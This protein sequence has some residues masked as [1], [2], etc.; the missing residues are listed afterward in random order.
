MRLAR[1][2]WIAGL[3]ASLAAHGAGA[4]LLA[5]RG[6]DVR[7]ERAAG[8]TSITVGSLQSALAAQAETEVLEPLET[9][10]TTAEMVKPAETETVTEATS[11]AREPVEETDKTETPDAP[12]TKP[13]EAR[14]ARQE[15]TLAAIDPQEVKA[16]E[17]PPIP[18]P[19]PKRA[20]DA[21]KAPAKTGRAIEGQQQKARSLNNS[22]AG[23]EAPRRTARRNT[24]AGEAG[25]GA[26]RG[27]NARLSNYQG[28]ILSRLQ[29]AKR[30][31]SDARRRGIEG[32]AVLSFT[33]GANG[34]V[35][36][37]RIARSSGHAVLDQAVMA[38]IRR[39]GPFPP[40]PPEIGR[41]RLPVRVPVQFAVR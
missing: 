31:P 7:M 14:A 20:S 34:Q 16:V 11:V 39:A 19:R 1:R 21:R 38:M 12:E 5:E 17:P 22:R 6:G 8:A 41:S 18:A 2:Y 27:G 28:M 25:T 30:Y 32:V 37:A 40:I 3:F 24:Q 15:L 4:A 35:N 33:V 26:V 13:V 23:A 29:R 10:G 36:G 9:T